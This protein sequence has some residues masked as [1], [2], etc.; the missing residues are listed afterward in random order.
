MLRIVP[1]VILMLLAKHMFCQDKTFNNWYFGKYWGLGFN[2]NPPTILMDSR[3]YTIEG[4]SSISDTAGHLLFYTDGC[5]VYD[6]NSNLMP[7]GTGL[8]GN[9]SST[10]SALIVPNPIK[11]NLYYIFT[12]DADGGYLGN[13]SCGGCCSYSTVDMNLNGSLGAVTQKNTFLFAP[14]SEKLAGY[15]SPNDSVIWVVAHKDLSNVFYVYKVDSNGV[16]QPPVVTSIGTTDN[17][18]GSWAT[19]AR[20]QMKISPDGTK[21]ALCSMFT[22]YLEIFDFDAVTGHISNPV[23]MKTDLRQCYGLEFSP[24]SKLLYL[25]D[26]HWN[27]SIC[28]YSLLNYN[29]SAIL[30]SKVIL[31]SYN[32]NYPY[33]Q[34]QLAPNG[35]IYLSCLDIGVYVINNPDVLGANCNLSVFSSASINGL[36]GH[37]IAKLGLPSHISGFYKTDYIPD[38][39]NPPAVIDPETIPCADLMIPNAISPNGDGV[40]DEFKINC[41]HEQAVPEDLVIYNRWGKEIYNR[42]NTVSFEKLS[43]GVYFYVFTYKE[44]RYKGYVSVFK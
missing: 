14:S 3:I 9:I 25:T 24:N 44:I 5:S 38:I 27:T 10:Q 19:I 4:S 17:G 29:D 41:N 23:T 40:N 43:A 21:I 35:K 22:N 8:F 1:V 31:D 30:S 13:S 20:G 34:L 33:S 36:Y 26:N 7:N 32:S 6:Q 42:K 12:T 16:H 18:S 11:K 28:Q 2:T 39:T 15:R 37:L